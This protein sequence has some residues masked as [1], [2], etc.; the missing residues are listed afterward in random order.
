MPDGKTYTVKDVAE[1]TGVPETTLRYYGRR[2]LLDFVAR[3]S[4]GVRIFTGNDFEALFIIHTLKE[5]GMSLA[6]I[7]HFMDLYFEGDSTIAERRRMYED[8][9]HKT[10][11][12]I[13]ALE[14]ALE[15]LEYKCWYMQEAERRGDAWWFRR[16]SERDV[17]QRVRDF[18]A[19]VGGYAH[20]SAQGCAY[21]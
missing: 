20:E 7:K 5:T 18:Y 19:K 14:S 16:L 10:R 1:R 21:M 13:A 17:P 11:M 6:S 3:N 8:Q 12:K 15:I 2:G 4:A 9:R